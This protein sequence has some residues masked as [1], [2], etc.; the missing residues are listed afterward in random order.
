MQ[1]QTTFGPIAFAIG[2]EIA[3][4]TPT[5]SAG[6]AEQ[7]AVGCLPRADSVR[8]KQP[9]WGVESV[10]DLLDLVARTPE[11]ADRAMGAAFRAQRAAD[12]LHLAGRSVTD[13][14]V[15]HLMSRH[16]EV[17]AMKKRSAAR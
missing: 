6:L 4:S 5:N 17:I 2:L 11:A 16:E 9:R 15:R 14:A 10:R 1:E 7:V 3:T 8:H 13:M 12:S